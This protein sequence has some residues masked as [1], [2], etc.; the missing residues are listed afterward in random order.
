VTL[1]SLIHH[2]AECRGDAL[3]LVFGPTRLTYRDLAVRMNRLAHALRERG[4]ER[5][6]R[7]AI[8]TFNCHQFIEAFFAAAQLGL[9]VVPLNFR[10]AGPELEYQ[11]TDS[12]AAAIVVGEELAGTV[13]GLRARL[14]GLAHGLVVGERIPAGMESYEAALRG[15]PTGR[16]PGPGGA[17]DDPFCIIYTSGTTGLPKGAL[18]TQQNVNVTSLNQILEWGCTGDDR[19]LTMAPMFHVGGS[20]VLTVPLLHVGGTAVVMER[21]D[22]AQALE[23]IE[24]ERITIVFGVPTMWT[25]IIEV[26]DIGRRDLRSLRLAVSGGASQP[27]AIMKRFQQALGVPFTEG[28]GLSESA[29]C[30]SVLRWEDAPRKAGSIGKPFIYNEMRV[31]DDD[32]RDVVPGQIGEIVQRGP[33]VMVGYWR[34]PEATRAAIRDG[35]LHT[36]DLGTVDEDG[37]FYCKDRKKDMIISGGENIYPAEVEQALYRHPDILEVAVVGVPDERWGEAVKAVVVRRPDRPLT[38]ADVVEWCR[39]SLA[40]YKKP[41]SVE[42]VDAL[43]RNASGK[44]L[45]Y[46]LRG[47]GQEPKGGKGSP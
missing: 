9:I 1:A 14:P 39:A 33:T 22:P 21:F 32:G 35:W 43:P 24:R 34:N 16:P 2:W 17:F 29:S 15:Q 10:L 26:P 13:A 44:V 12:E 28:Y 6:D 40:S 18:L 45:K 8:L 31:V 20:L 4:L 19:T 38:E 37:F 23:L 47:S 25:S 30:S 11:L 42:F 36:G 7:L 46:R 27:L 3:A 5:G 41:R